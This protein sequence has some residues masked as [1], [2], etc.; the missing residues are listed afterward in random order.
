MTPIGNIFATQNS[1]LSSSKTI[2]DC[3]GKKVLIVDDGEVNIKLASRYLEQFHF[4][5]DSAN[6]GRECVEKVKN[7]QYDLILLDRMMPDMD[8]VATLKALNA[9]GINLPP[10][11]ALTAN[12]FDESKEAYVAEGFNDYL[13]KPIIFKELNKV[14][15]GIFHKEE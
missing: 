7:N 14:I 12:S 4:A 11:V 2:I 1:V 3:T 5:I 13:R 8:G 10:V 15:K 6:S 9:L